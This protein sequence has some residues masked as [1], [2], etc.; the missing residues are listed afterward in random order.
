MMQRK[1]A[2]EVPQTM[3]EVC[4]CLGRPIWIQS[5]ILVGVTLAA[6]QE[7]VVLLRAQRYGG[8]PPGIGI[9]FYC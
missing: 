3:S 5:V 6:Y 7:C 9:P 1:Q 2:R 4:C 8:F